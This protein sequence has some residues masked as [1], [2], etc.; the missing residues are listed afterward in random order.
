M[1]RILAENWRATTVVPT[2]AHMEVDDRVVEEAASKANP[3]APDAAWF[4]MRQPGILRY[5]ETRCPNG[6]PLAV[7]LTTALAI[8]AAYEQ[9]LGGPPPRVSSTLVEQAERAVLTELGARAKS[10][11]R[12][13]ALS[14]FVAGVMASP[15]TPL[16]EEESTSVGLALIAVVYALDQAAWSGRP[17]QTA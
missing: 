5:L 9:A 15:P 12:Q 16:D 13:R 14:E 2:I 1:A 6:D 3:G 10:T 4:A 11:S 17:F 8:H 7:A